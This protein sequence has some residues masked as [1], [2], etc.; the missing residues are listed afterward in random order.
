MVRA[1]SLRRRS[2]NSWAK[3]HNPSIIHGDLKADNVLIDHNGNARLCDFGLSRMLEDTTLWETSSSKA[4]GTLRWIAPEL[5]LPSEDQTPKTVSTESDI[6]AF[7]MTC[8]EVY[9]GLVPFH[10]YRHDGA[11]MMAVGIR[12]EIPQRKSGLDLFTDEKWGLCTQTWARDPPARPTS[13]AVL[14]FLARSVPEF[15]SES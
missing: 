6:Y 13:L 12:G 5:L 11:V 4:S 9:T 3:G 10:Q 1:Y 8:Y 14:G 2:Y 7:G 15:T